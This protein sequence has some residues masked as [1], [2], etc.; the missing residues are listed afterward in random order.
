MIGG[1]LTDLD[2]LVLTCRT[3]EASNYIR[4]AIQSYRAGAYR[5]SIVVTWI[6]VV[7]DLVDKIRELDESGDLQAKAV[8]A[9]FDNTLALLAKGDLTSMPKALQFEREI[10]DTVRTNFQLLDDHQYDEMQRIFK[11]RN[12]CAHP[13]F[14]LSGGTYQPSA[15]LARTHIRNAIA[16]VLQQP[17]VQGKAAI[18]LVAAKLRSQYFPSDWKLAKQALEPLI[19]RARPALI[20]GLVDKILWDMIKV[21]AP[22]APPASIA[23]LQ[24]VLE[25]HRA[26]AEPRIRS[27]TAKI[28]NSV[29]DDKLSISC[30]MVAQ[31]PEAWEGLDQSQR[32]RFEKYLMEGDIYCVAHLLKL[33]LERPVLRE[34]ALAR[35]KSLNTSELSQVIEAG[36]RSEIVDRVV[37]LFSNAKNWAS[38][39]HISGNLVLPLIDQITPEHARIIIKSPTERRSD[40]PYSGGAAAFIAAVRGKNILSELELN[41][42]L[43]AHKFDYLLPEDEVEGGAENPA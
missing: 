21:D 12:R 34:P 38:A 19:G 10:L 29:S 35:I 16:H 31:I 22:H 7:F 27:Q 14:N 8:I 39:N 36:I 2:E 43:R 1:G 5:A 3:Q 26:A 40:L 24:A 32:H 42:L 18:E 28:F 9:S 37:D 20:N 30:S 17:P 25:L 6:A 41:A 13:T 4:E 15:E 11:D 23:A 33:S